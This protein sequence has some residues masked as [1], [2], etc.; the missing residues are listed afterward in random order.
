M[1]T[2]RKNIQDKTPQIEP[3]IQ[4]EIVIS[5]GS[6]GKDLLVTLGVGPC[7][8]LIMSDPKSKFT[9]S[10]HVDHHMDCETV[11]K[12]CLDLLKQNNIPLDRVTAYLV[13][14]WQN[15][16]SSKKQGETLNQLL[17]AQN[18]N[19][20]K[21]LFFQRNCLSINYN[22]FMNFARENMQKVI[23]DQSM[24]NDFFAVIQ[25]RDPLYSA[26]MDG[27]YDQLFAKLLHQFCQS[28]DKNVS[29]LIENSLIL[30]ASKDQKELIAVNYDL[31]TLSYFPVV[32]FDQNKQVL[33]YGNE[34]CNGLLD[35]LSRKDEKL[36]QRIKHYQQRD[37]FYTQN[38]PD[39]HRDKNFELKMSM[40]IIDLLKKENINTHPFF[41]KPA[42]E[43]LH[44]KQLAELVKKYKLPN[45]QQ[46][47]LEKGLRNAAHNDQAEDLKIFLRFVKNIDAKDKNPNSEKTALHLAVI[48]QSTDCIK[49][50]LDNNARTD[51]KDKSEKTAADYAQ[52]EVLKL[53]RPK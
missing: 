46:D 51:I 19:C 45:S 48:K 10:A 14:G 32:A 15:Y 23:T 4:G 25:H 26:D 3:F 44:E 5:N 36:F 2:T 42:E 43:K 20:N 27:S 17:A 22:A 33:F 29:T 39:F 53:L 47:S 38:Q 11:L 21:E 6:T 40:S 34:L 16:S 24:L 37:Q 31:P 35:Y 18:V 13:G 9:I 28:Q 7:L 52:N 1:L 50:L 8:V 41:E 49:L 12:I 30:T